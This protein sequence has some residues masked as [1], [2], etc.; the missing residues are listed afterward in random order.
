MWMRRNAGRISINLLSN[1]LYLKT[2][3][4]EDTVVVPFFLYYLIY[5]YNFPETLLMVI[6]HPSGP[7]DR[8][9]AH[10]APARVAVRS[11][12][13][14]DPALIRAAPVHA[15]TARPHLARRA[16]HARRSLA[17]SRTRTSPRGCAP[18]AYPCRGPCRRELHTM[19]SSSA[20][21]SSS[22][23]TSSIRPSSKPML[24]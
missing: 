4:V 17:R 3:T 15:L 14:T 20:R 8:A 1:L 12:R 24:R 2:S 10:A 22:T 9:L 5:I 19:A 11:A 7:T 21:A 18:S 16:R 6:G 13:G 23:S